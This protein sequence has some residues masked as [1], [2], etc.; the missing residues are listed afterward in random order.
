MAA[1]LVLAVGPALAYAVT[2]GLHDAS[3]AIPA[4]LVTLGGELLP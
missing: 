3:N 4:V 1:A 2:N